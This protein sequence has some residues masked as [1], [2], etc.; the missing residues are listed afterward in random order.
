MHRPELNVMETGKIP[1]H[2]KWPLKPFFR[3]RSVYPCGPSGQVVSS[4]RSSRSYDVLADIIAVNIVAII[5]N[6]S[7]ISNWEDYWLS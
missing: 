2:K 6:F 7:I 4:D 5:V 3:S 1:E